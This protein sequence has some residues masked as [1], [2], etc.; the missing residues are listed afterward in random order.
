MHMVGMY[1]VRELI[2]WCMCVCVVCD[3]VCIYIYLQNIYT[4]KTKKRESERDKKQQK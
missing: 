2:I 3:D 1:V 4:Q